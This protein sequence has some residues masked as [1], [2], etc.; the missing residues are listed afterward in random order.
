MQAQAQATASPRA[1]TLEHG[2]A[3]ATLAAALSAGEFKSLKSFPPPS[4]Q[5]E[6]DANEVGLVFLCVHLCG[7]APHITS[8][9][10]VYRH[11]D[12]T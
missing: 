11:T 8:C 10:K 7:I 3:N 4:K 1:R 12:Q 2:S 6:D 5:P 9:M